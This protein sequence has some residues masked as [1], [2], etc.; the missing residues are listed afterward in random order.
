MSLTSHSDP[1]IILFPTFTMQLLYSFP[2]LLMRKPRLNKVTLSNYSNNSSIITEKVEASWNSDSVSQSS[3]HLLLILRLSPQTA[4]T[5][6]PIP[7]L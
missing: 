3:K 5:R 4:G 1:V 7:D 6:D 2:H